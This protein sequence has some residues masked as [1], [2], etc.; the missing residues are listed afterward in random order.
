MKLL[1]QQV[2]TLQ[3]RLADKT[4]DLQVELQQN[5]WNHEEAMEAN[6]IKM[7]ELDLKYGVEGQKLALSAAELQHELSQPPQTNGTMD[8]D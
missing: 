3:T 5:K 8:E 1:E 6:A 4:R 2:A 7:R